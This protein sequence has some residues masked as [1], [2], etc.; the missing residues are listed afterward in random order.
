MSS[1]STDVG[2]FT[3]RPMSELLPLMSNIA[4]ERVDG[5]FYQYFGFNEPI[6]PHFQHTIR[7]LEIRDDDIITL[8]FPRSGNHFAFEVV[9]MVQKQSTEYVKSHMIDNVLELRK[10]DTYESYRQEPSPRNLTINFQVRK[11]P[12]Q[13]VEKRTKIVY[14]LRN[15]KDAL[16]SFYKHWIKLQADDMGFRGTWEEFLDLS[17][18]GQFTYGSWFDHVL[19]MERY[20]ADHPDTPVHVH[21]FEEMVSEPLPTVKKLCKFLGTSEELAP[22]IAEVTDFGYM[23]KNSSKDGE[24]GDRFLQQGAAFMRKGTKLDWKNNFTV[25]QNE[26][27]NKIFEEKMAGSKLADLVRPYL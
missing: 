20:M 24:I 12:Q 2:P 26:T 1:A 27:F 18:S 13:A 9:N 16:T 5:I 23:K 22:K 21:L 3:G 4:G 11:I 19:C 15:P 14:L 10:V 25:A 8:G 6:E 7:N 17:V